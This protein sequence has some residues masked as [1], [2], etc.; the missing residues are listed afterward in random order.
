MREAVFLRQNEARWKQYEQRATGPEELAAR[1]VALT[2]DLAYAQTFYPGSPTTHYLNDLTAR[3]HQALYKNKHESTGRFADFWRRELPLLVARHH[4][5][6]AW[7]LV[8]FTLFTA[9]GA[10]SAAYDD[11]FVR[12]VL[13]DAYVN[14]TLENIERGDPMAVYK[15]SSETP[16]FLFITLNNIYVSLVA[17]ALGATLGLGT[18]WALFRNGVMLGSFQYFFYQKNLLLPSVL[19]IWIHGTL[20]IS[21]IVL[22]GGAGLVMARGMLFP[23][24]Y[25]R[26]ESFRQAA[27]DGLKL[28][29]GLVP[30]FVT[31][32]F[33]EGFVTRHT[34]MPLVLSLL[35]I[36]SSAAFIIWYFIL[37]P[38]RLAARS[39]PS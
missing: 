21:A 37:Y 38:R 17:Y 1:F 33:L 31:A 3:Q 4:R 10:L 29:V 18:V 9:I 27:R 22:A 20:E 16:M 25:S 35:I 2:D 11:S 34:E 36:G 6:L 23:G 24:T 7:S 26:T 19:T 39:R 13:G 5:T 32:G 30:I 14:R 15:S 28:A 8:L 12:V